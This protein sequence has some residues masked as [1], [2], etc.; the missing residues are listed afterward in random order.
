[1]IYEAI[2]KACNELVAGV[3]GTDDPLAHGQG[4]HGCC[5]NHI[6]GTGVQEHLQS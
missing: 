1:M 3:V 5:G 4:F 6:T 2:A